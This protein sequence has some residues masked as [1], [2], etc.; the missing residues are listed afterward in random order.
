VGAVVNG[1]RISWEEYG[2]RAKEIT[3][4]RVQCIRCTNC[5]RLRHH[6]VK[7]DPRTWNCGCGGMSFQDAFPHNDE[8]SL[9]IKLYSRE[10]EIN[11]L[12]GHLAMEVIHKKDNEDTDCALDGRA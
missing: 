2:R 11:N 8:L 10:I 9:A 3:D 1:R 6:P 4:P 12:Y 7:D 5:H